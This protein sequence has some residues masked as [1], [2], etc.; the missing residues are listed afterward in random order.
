MGNFFEIAKELKEGQVATSRFS[1]AITKVRGSIRHCD[2]EG[3]LDRS[4]GKEGYVTNVEF[5]NKFTWEVQDE[6]IQIDLNETAKRL[7]ERLP[8]YIDGQKKRISALRDVSDEGIRDF[9]DAFVL[10][11][12]YKK[13]GE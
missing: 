4:T 5:L 2:E 7:H 10:T 13:R 9:E 12:Y 6:F 11:K 1:T 3:N 8:V